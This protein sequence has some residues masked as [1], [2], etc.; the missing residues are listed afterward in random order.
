MFKKLLILLFVVLIVGFALIPPWTTKMAEDAFKDPDNKLSPAKVKKALKVKMYLYMFP[1][2]RKM[3]EKAVIYFPESEEFAYFIYTAALSSE[4]SNAPLAAMY[5]YN[6]FVQMYPKH[7]LTAQAQS[8]YEKLKGI[9]T[10]N[11]KD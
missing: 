9:H 1:E 6:F 5:W 2:A 10:T 11:T 3:S 4:K 8:S 7:E